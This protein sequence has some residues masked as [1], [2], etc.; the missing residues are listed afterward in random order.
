MD[1][2]NIH[3]YTKMV[4]NAV[5]ANEIEA[6]RSSHRANVECRRAIDDAINEN[7]SYSSYCLNAKDAVRIVRASFSDE[8]I[9]YVLAVC[10]I[11]KDWDGRIS[12]QN[13]EWAKTIAP[14]MEDSNICEYITRCHPGLLNLFMDEFRAQ[15][16]ALPA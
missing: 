15:I 13:K 4:R 5:D 2:K 7:Y 12:R 3:L 14:N 8:R 16:Y 11:H 9:A 6:Y 10:A 1:C